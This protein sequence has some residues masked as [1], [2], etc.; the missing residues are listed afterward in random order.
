MPLLSPDGIGQSVRGGGQVSEARRAGKQMEQA[1]Q[2]LIGNRSQ[3]S[4][5]GRHLSN[6][7]CIEGHRCAWHVRVLNLFIF[8]FFLQLSIR[9][10]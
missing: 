4:T 9:G 6:L 8:L 5:Y 2:D 1:K 3:V 10:R 7:T